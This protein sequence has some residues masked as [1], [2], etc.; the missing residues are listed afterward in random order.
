MPI[1]SAD[2][3]L[4]AAMEATGG[5]G[6]GGAL[7]EAMTFLPDELGAADRVEASIAPKLIRRA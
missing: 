5:D 1:I 7:S 3:A 2:E 6:A 4:A